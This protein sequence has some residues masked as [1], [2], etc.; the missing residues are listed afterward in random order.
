MFFSLAF[1]PSHVFHLKVSIRHQKH[2]CPLWQF[3]TVIYLQ[4]MFYV[5]WLTTGS[6]AFFLKPQ[7][8][9]LL[10]PEPVCSV[11][12]QISHEECLHVFRRVCD[13]YIILE[14][15]RLCKGRPCES[16]RRSPLTFTSRCAKF[17][18]LF[19]ERAPNSRVPFSPPN[20]GSHSRAWGQAAASCPAGWLLTPWPP[21]NPLF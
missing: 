19:P 9:N 18:H 20:F 7:W 16:C 8:N 13:V 11:L 2:F 12:D 6:F 15:S 4:S 5:P 21:S 1:V 14:V 10:I 3:N 17:V